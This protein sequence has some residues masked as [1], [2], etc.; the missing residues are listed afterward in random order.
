MKELEISKI[1]KWIDLVIQN[2]EE[3]ELL[4]NIY[5]DV[6]ALCQDYP[7]YPD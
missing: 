4:S 6:N 2:P 3:D 1:V 7:V 5:A